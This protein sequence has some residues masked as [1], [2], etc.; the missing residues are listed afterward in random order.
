MANR[1]DPTLT[2]QEVAKEFL[3]IGHGESDT[4]LGIMLDAAFEFVQEETALL[5]NESQAANAYYCTGGGYNLWTP[6]GPLVSV[7]SVYDSVGE[8]D[9]A[10]STFDFFSERRLRRTGGLRWDDGHDRY[11]VTVVDGYTAATLPASL[12]LG[13][14][15]L[16]ERA[17]RSPGARSKESGA[18]HSWDWQ[19]LCDSD[20]LAQLQR[21]SMRGLVA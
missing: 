2:D 18:G 1:L 5:L 9:V 6:Y 11:L 10:A 16:V 14:L 3:Q 15:H 7:S 20:I 17:Y 13:V 8:V 19:A 21:H 4:V 12:K